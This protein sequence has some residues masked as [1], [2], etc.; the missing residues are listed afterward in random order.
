VTFTDVGEWTNSANLSA[1]EPDPDT[2]NNQPNLNIDVAQAPDLV[3]TPAS[4]SLT[5]Q[6]GA[7]GT[8]VFTFTSLGGFTGDV[9]LT[10]SVAGPAPAPACTMSPSSVTAG[11]NPVTA[12]LKLTALSAALQPTR[13]PGLFYA[14]LLPL[15]GLAFIGIGFTSGKSRKRKTLAWLLCALVLGAITLQSACGGGDNNNPPPQP[16]IYTVTVTASAGSISKSTQIQ[17]TVQ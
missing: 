8:D 14:A 4:P 7:S 9:S 5:M 11:P 16:R 15:P 1:T 6:R 12:M 2:S 3:V 17:L 10:C 13:Q